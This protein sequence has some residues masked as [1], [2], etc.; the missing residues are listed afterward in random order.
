MQQRDLFD[1][2]EALSEADMA[3]EGAFPI[4]SGRV[5]VIRFGATEASFALIRDVL[6][7]L[8]TPPDPVADP[9]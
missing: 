3:E 9:S 6:A 1:S 7:D 2:D 5:G 4:R 8:N